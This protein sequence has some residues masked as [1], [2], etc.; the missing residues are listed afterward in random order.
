MDVKEFE[1]FA[2]I[3]ELGSITQAANR[4]FVTQSALSKFVQRKEAE[5]GTALFEKV[6]KRF[7]LTQAGEVCL[8]ASREIIKL[9]REMIRDVD[10][11]AGGKQR[12]R[13]AYPLTCSDM[14]FM[15]IYPQFLRRFPKIDLQLHEITSSQVIEMF[16]KGDL[17]LAIGTPPAE[18]RARYRTFSMCQIHFVVTVSR[19][20]PLIAKT[21]LDPETGRAVIAPEELNDFPFILRHKGSR[22]RE[23]SER[24]MAAYGIRPK[25]ILEAANRE[26]ALRAAEYGIG[27]TFVPSDPAMLIRH[28]NL[29]F[30]DCKNE[31]PAT[32][33]FAFCLKS[34]WLSEAE[35]CLIELFCAQYTVLSG[36]YELNSSLNKNMEIDT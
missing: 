7:V 24:W 22:I 19:Q 9:N 33:V 28:P 16:S 8:K 26:N 21:Y 34:K 29:V 11:I 32:T 14:F 31:E 5:M 36:V 1:Y 30:I 2:T 15:Y 13:F 12:I 6:G 25:V 10:A 4:L 23:A 17:D 20:S 18:E 27:A 35:R 3:A